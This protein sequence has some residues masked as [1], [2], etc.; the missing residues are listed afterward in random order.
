MKKKIKFLL[1]S[2]FIIDYYKIIIDYKVLINFIALTA[3]F[4]IDNGFH[5]RILIGVW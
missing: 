1:L 3:I 5:Y 4:F 2:N